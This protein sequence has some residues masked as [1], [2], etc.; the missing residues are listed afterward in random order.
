[1]DIHKDKSDKK[2]KIWRSERLSFKDYDRTVGIPTKTR[3]TDRKIEQKERYQNLTSVPK[4]IENTIDNNFED[5]ITESVFFSESFGPVHDL[6]G[7]IKNG[8]LPAELDYQKMIK[9]M[10][11]PKKAVYKN[12]YKL[13]VNGLEGTVDEFFSIIYSSCKKPLF[14]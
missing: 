3:N 1:M 9:N 4:I 8:I 13:V 5:S 11:Y 6:E 12:N 2:H 7:L 10:F 14:F